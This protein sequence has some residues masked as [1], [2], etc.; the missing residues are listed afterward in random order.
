M[1]KTTC[2][3]TASLHPGRPS[4][5]VAPRDPGTE[6]SMTLVTISDGCHR[7][8]K[9]WPA[10]PPGPVG[11]CAPVGVVVVESHRRPFER[12]TRF[13]RASCDEADA[14]VAMRF[15]GREG[16]WCPE[17]VATQLVF[18]AVGVDGRARRAVES[19]AKALENLRADVVVGLHAAMPKRTQEPGIG[20]IGNIQ[21]RRIAATPKAK[22]ASKV[23]P[24]H[25]RRFA[26][27][28]IARPTVTVQVQE[29][30][31]KFVRPVGDCFISSRYGMR[32]ARHHNG[33]DLA[34][35]M[36]TPI[37]ASDGG[38]IV[39]AGYDGPGFG[40]LI[41]IRHPNGW[42]TLYAHL[43][44]SCVLRGQ[45]VRQGEVIGLVGSTGRSTG[46]H[47]HFEIRDNEDKPHNPLNFVEEP[48]HP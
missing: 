17:H 16:R 45:S 15:G 20:G 46:P 47:L 3:R 40:N 32:G 23:A 43:E 5:L 28:V 11:L 48:C 21:T 19:A 1:Q 8:A 41:E 18:G 31:Q 26:E 27:K 29:P 37:L 2:R 34:A 42:T 35:E 13:G 14:H 12:K 39:F 22:N 9:G 6:P 10:P 25:V 33:V 7:V 24:V 36:G 38:E 4:I 30:K 44:K